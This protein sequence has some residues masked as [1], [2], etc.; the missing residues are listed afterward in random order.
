MPG[1]D[2]VNVIS[3]NTI[4]RINST[5]GAGETI[6]IRA[7]T[8][9]SII[10][11]AMNPTNANN[12]RNIFLNGRTSLTLLNGQA[13]TFIKIDNR[14]VDQSDPNNLNKGENSTYQLMSISN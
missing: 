12:G 13:A 9:S 7:N 5:I 8:G 14:I 11:N 4:N 10:F 3:S 6:F 2:D 1:P